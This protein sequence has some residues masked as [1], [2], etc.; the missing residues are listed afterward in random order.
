MAVAAWQNLPPVNALTDLCPRN[1]GAGVK[2]IGWVDV[3]GGFRSTTEMMCSSSGCLFYYGD[4][5][6]IRTVS[7]LGEDLYIRMSFV[8][9][10]SRRKKRAILIASFASVAGIVLCLVPITFLWLTSLVRGDLDLF[11]RACWKMNRKL[12]RNLVRL[13]GGCIEREENMLI[14]EYLPNSSL[15]VI[16]FDQTKSRLLNWE[17]RFNIINGIAKGIL[18]LHQDSRCFGGNEIEAKTRRVVG[19]YG[20]MSLEYAIDWVFSIK[21]DVFSFS[22]PVLEIVSGK[23]N[24]GFCLE[25]HDLNLLGHAWRL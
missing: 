8:E 10:E 16:I 17:K 2:R 7:A 13:L 18:Y 5:L 1:W 9:S 23:R 3:L 14:Y 12:H 20:Y 4:L 19:T 11:T 24:R 22:V 21:S 6:D 25:D 15:V